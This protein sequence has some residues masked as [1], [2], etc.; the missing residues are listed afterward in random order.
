V[1]A[2]VCAL[3]ALVL[4]ERAWEANAGVFSPE[5]RAVGE[6]LLSLDQAHLFA[7]WPA[8]GTD[9][10]EKKRFLKQVADVE[11]AYL[12]GVRTYVQRAQA[13]LKNAALGANPYEG[14]RVEAPGSDVAVRV[15]SPA[16]FAK[17]EPLGLAQASRTAFVIVAGGLGERLGYKGIKLALPS[18][19]STE[20]SYI[21]L[22][23]RWILALQARARQAENNP[24]L[25]LQFAIMTSDDTDAMTRALLEANKNFGLTQT[26]LTV[27]KQGK[28]PSLLDNQAHF[29]LDEKDK[30]A[31]D[32]KPHG[33][34]DV[35]SLLYGQ[36][37]VDRWVNVPASAPAGSRLPVEWI[38]F[39]Q[40][41]FS[42]NKQ[43]NSCAHCVT[44]QCVLALYACCC[45]GRE[46][47]AIVLISCVF[48]LMRFAL[49]RTPTASCSIR[50]CPRLV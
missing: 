37:I 44:R 1:F 2:Y 12:G 38:V 29:V 17:Y 14:F 6:Q 9:D 7:S 21:E 34:G 16:D 15:D 25:E 33:H 30:Y 19:I 40:V 3:C 13:L 31:L 5:L 46:H 4:S 22:Y 48:V 42:H 36:G 50:S 11:A 32:T 23:A 24:A 26:Q 27:F 39:F 18:D 41:G 35:H 49:R 43:T 28:V 45:T 8:P 47:A 20:V 10:E